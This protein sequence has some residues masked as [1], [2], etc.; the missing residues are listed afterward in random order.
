MIA[1]MMYS[2]YWCIPVLPRGTQND[3]VLITVIINVEGFVLYGLLLD[4]III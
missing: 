2:F 3:P 4:H 1:L